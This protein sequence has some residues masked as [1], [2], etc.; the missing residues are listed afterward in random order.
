M[1]TLEPIL[2]GKIIQK[3]KVGDNKYYSLATVNLFQDTFVL[4]KYRLKVSD[5]VGFNE[6]LYIEDVIDTILITPIT[7]S[8]KVKVGNEYKTI[9]C[10]ENLV[11]NTNKALVGSAIV[12]SSRI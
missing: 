2:E 4:D 7:P 12:G 5:G 6:V 8:L 9:L 1:K 10:L 3:I 11:V